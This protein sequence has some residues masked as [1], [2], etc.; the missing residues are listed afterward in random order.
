M[1]KTQTKLNLKMTEDEYMNRSESYDGICLACGHIH[2][3]GHEPDAR[4]Y[5]CENCGANRVYGIE[6]LMLMG[7]I[8]IVSEDEYDL[9]DEF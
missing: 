1:A 9:E 4:G 5:E 3:G 7:E 2:M 6:E 8:E